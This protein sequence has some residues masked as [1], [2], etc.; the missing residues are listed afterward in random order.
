MKE[1]IILL[2]ILKRIYAMSNYCESEILNVFQSQINSSLPSYY[3]K[4]Y[5][6]SG[7]VINA[8]GNYDSCND[9]DQAKY[10]VFSYKFISPAEVWT[11]C[12]PVACTESDYYD[13]KS[14]PLQYLDSGYEVIFPVSYQE[15]NYGTL[16]TGAVIMISFILFVVVLA[17]VATALDYWIDGEKRSKRVFKYILC[18]SIISNV[19][20]ILSERRLPNGEKDTLEL[21][22]GIKAISMGWVVFYH[23]IDRYINVASL[24]NYDTKYEIISESKYIIYIGSSYCV[25]SFFWIS[26]LL[27]GYFYTAEVQNSKNFSAKSIAMTLLHRY[28]RL[29]PTFIFI[30]LFYWSLNAY[31]GNGPLWYNADEFIPQCSEYWWTS[32]IYLNNF[33]P[34]WRGNNCLPQIWFIANEMQFFIVS[35]ALI[36]FYVKVSKTATWVLIFL[37]SVISVVISGV[38]ADYYDYNA[39]H[40]SLSN[41]NDYTDFYYVK[42]YTRIPPYIFGVLCGFI[43]YSYRKNKQDSNFVYDKFALYLANIQENAYIR[44]ITFVIGFGIINTLIFINLEPMRYPDNGY[45]DYWSHTSNTLFTA[46]H[47][48]SYSIGISLT[49]IPLLLGHFKL[50]TKFLSLYVWSVIAKLVYGIYLIHCNAIN[51]I[52]RSQENVSMLDYYNNVRDSFYFFILILLLAIPLSLFIELPAGNLEK[53][54]FEKEKEKIPEQKPLIKEN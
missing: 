12:G 14:T 15:E 48:F 31:L 42:P 49:F 8:L 10:V 17:L 7:L 44:V 50:I 45:Y 19:K 51:N 9:I 22:N 20:T 36:V 39:I 41:G 26:G 25:D 47:R 27:M 6:Y 4:M 21:L 28:L 2:I 3:N 23:T 34:N 11:F 16:S 43:I 30:V 5:Q 52:L 38:L 18:F 46:F 1:A 29:T 32:L 54:A 33:I 13:I 37:I 24:S 40:S 53:L 35:V